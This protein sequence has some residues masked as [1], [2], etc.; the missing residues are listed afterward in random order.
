[1]KLRTFQLMLILYMAAGAAAS[2]QESAT[3]NSPAELWEDYDPEALPLEIESLERWTDDGTQFE[4]LRF[5][6]E[7]FEGGKARVL[8]IIGKSSAGT[9]QPGIL[10]I[11]GGGQTASLD[12]VKFWTKRGYA[13]VTFDFCGVWENR[14]EFTDWGPL[15]HGNMAHAAGGFQVAPTPR[16]SSWYHWTIAARRALTLLASQPEVDRERLGIFGIS[17]G[18]T[19]CWSVAASDGRVKT[20]VPIYGCGYNVDGLRT[21]WGFPKLTPELALFQRAVSPEAHA[22]Y[23]TCPILFL[24]ATNDFHGWMDD[25]MTCWPQC[26]VRIGRPLR[27]GTTITLPVHRPPTCRRWMDRQ[28]A[29]D[30]FPASPPLESAWRTTECRGLVRAD[31]GE[32]A[33]RWTLIMRGRQA[34][35]NR[36]GGAWPAPNRRCLAGRVAGGR[37]VETDLR[38]CECDLRLGSLS[39]QQLGAVDPAKHG[40]AGATLV[41]NGAI[42]QPMA[43]DAWYRVTANTDPSIE[44]NYLQVSPDA[45]EGPIVVLD[46]ADVSW[47]DGDLSRHPPDDDP[48]FLAPGGTTLAFECGGGRRRRV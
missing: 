10:H 42:D 9:R 43:A 44:R 34:G 48:Q 41:N 5:T 7:V 2:A 21:E 4:K 38:F 30:G 14:Q 37:R 8:A 33:F 16:E 19:L 3:I 23:I 17:M 46:P 24:N 40:K 35:A 26:R 39:D 28:L 25:G 32:V 29:A 6:S 12:W 22:P 1:M 47:S 11:H 20:A 36:F 45:A 31:D 18:G 15:K 27:R 13:C